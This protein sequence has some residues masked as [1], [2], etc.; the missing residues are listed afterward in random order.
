MRIFEGDVARLIR[1]KPSAYDA[2]LFDVGNGP[3]G[4]TRKSNDSLYSF[5]GLLDAYVALRPGGVLAVWSAGPDNRLEQRLPKVG[6]EV[7]ERR[8]RA[9]GKKGTRHLIW[10]A[11]K[12]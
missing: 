3:E 8:V 9:H 5:D 4:L 12:R 6:F 10:I 2:I 7:E 1:G 11:T